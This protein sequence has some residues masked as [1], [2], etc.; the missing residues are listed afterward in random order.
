MGEL[1]RF[2]ASLEKLSCEKEELNQDLH[3][4]RDELEQIKYKVGIKERFEE[5]KSQLVEEVTTIQDVKKENDRFL[6][7]VENP[8]HHIREVERQ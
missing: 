2:N 3:L 7:D 8:T 1:N 4:T 6:K 5:E